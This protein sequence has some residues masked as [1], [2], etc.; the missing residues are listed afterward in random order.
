[1]KGAGRE[2]NPYLLVHS[3]AC[4]GRYTTCTKS[5]RLK[6]ELQLQQ[7]DQDSNPDHLVRSEA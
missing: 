4:S 6:P 3:Q 2:S 1:M 7:L 5:R